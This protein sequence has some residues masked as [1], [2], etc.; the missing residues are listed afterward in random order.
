MEQEK[1]YVW[2]IQ[3]WKEDG[4]DLFE[5]VDYADVL[6]GGKIIKGKDFGRLPKRYKYELKKYLGDDAYKLNRFMEIGGEEVATWDPS[7]E[8]Y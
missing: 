6:K 8:K 5:L 3:K 1:N 2:N 7:G 4:E